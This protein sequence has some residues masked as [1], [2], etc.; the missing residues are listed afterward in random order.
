[1]EENGVEWTDNI[2]TVVGGLW[3]RA[4]TP[5]NA[6]GGD[7]IRSGESTAIK[8]GVKIMLNTKGDELIVEDGRVVGAKATGENNTPVIL[9]ANRGVVIASGGFAA[10]TEM[11]QK[12]D[13]TLIE[14]LPTTNTP[15]AQGDG[16][17][18]AETVDASVIGME[19]IQSLPFGDPADGA[20]SGW[21]GSGVETFYLVN[22]EGE[23]FMAE[24]GRRDTMTAALLAQTDAYAYV[25]TGYDEN[26]KDFITSIN[27]WGD[28]IDELVETGRVFRAD[29]IE[30]LAEQ[31]GI[32][33]AVLKE[34]HDKFNAAV[35][36]VVD[37]E[38]GRTLFGSKIETG[39]FFASPRVPTVHHTMGGIE[40][41]LSGEVFNKD[42][43]VI[44]GLYAAGEVT[45]G[46]HG[47][48]RLGGN[49]LVDIHVFGRTAGKA[50]AN[51]K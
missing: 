18:M 1:M 48:S 25:I 49:A 51:N 43:E 11:R 4:H 47:K 9:H 23:R 38:F 2:H 41:N 26:H 16:I 31:I 35:E 40:I 10:N 24:D 45:G 17:T 28:V 36:S 3:P 34:T 8:L 29:T 6:A 27:Y 50:A 32:D 14:S 7:Y 20:L 21:V 33:P 30:E 22:K 39:P 44:E 19:Y 42:G 46:I 37:E 5:I 12:Y 13:S 15:A